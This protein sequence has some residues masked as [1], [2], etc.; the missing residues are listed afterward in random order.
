[1]CPIES[2]DNTGEQSCP[3]SMVLCFIVRIE[4]TENSDYPGEDGFVSRTQA[5]NSHSEAQDP[6][7]TETK[8]PGEEPYYRRILRTRS[9]S[10]QIA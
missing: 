2:T 1:M 6:L 7:P 4:Y 5:I 8:R 9:R 10:W 3:G